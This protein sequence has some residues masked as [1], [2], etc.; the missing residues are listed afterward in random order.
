MELSHALDSGDPWDVSWSPG[1]LQGLTFRVN[2]CSVPGDCTS[3]QLDG[4]T[5]VLGA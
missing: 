4:V 3:T 1:E 5:V 2:I